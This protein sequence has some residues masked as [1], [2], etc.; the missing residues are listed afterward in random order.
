MLA[1]DIIDGIR[2]WADRNPQA[3]DIICGIALVACIAL[4]GLIE[5]ADNMIHY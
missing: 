5:G 1:L 2:R 3:F 4:A